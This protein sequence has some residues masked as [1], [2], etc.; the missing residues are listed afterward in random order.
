M[1]VLGT[2]ILLGAPAEN[3]RMALPLGTH[4]PLATSAYL[5]RILVFT[6]RTLAAACSLQSA[7]PS[8]ALH[9]END[10]IPKNS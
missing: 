6:A 3:L 9:P 2:C 8:A 7:T 10:G 1:K 4:I 5:H